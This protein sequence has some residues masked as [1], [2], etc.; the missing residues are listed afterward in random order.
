MAA[1]ACRSLVEQRLTLRATPPFPHPSFLIC[2]CANRHLLALPV[3]STVERSNVEGSYGQAPGRI[4]P[5]P[6]D[7]TVRAV[8]RRGELHDP[9]RGVGS[10]RGRTASTRVGSGSRGRAGERPCA[11]RLR[12]CRTATC[13]PVTC[14]TSRS[15]PVFLPQACPPEE[16]L[17]FPSDLVI[18]GFSRSRLGDQHHM[19]VVGNAV[20]HA[21]VGLSQQPSRPVADHRGAGALA[22]AKPC[23]PP[24][25][26]AAAPPED[27]ITA[28]EPCSIREDS[29]PLLP[30]GEPFGPGQTFIRGHPRFIV[31]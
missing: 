5:G 29:L 9:P 31:G 21:T 14:A 7:G 15:L 10:P 13:R 16:L 22:S 24:D 25:P 23:L 26:L 30:P 1:S 4:R 2:H 12:S 3:P 8:S 17:Q 11:G 28:G 6:T 19:A 27:R 18:A 20:F